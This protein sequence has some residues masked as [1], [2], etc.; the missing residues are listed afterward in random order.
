MFGSSSDVS[1]LVGGT[2]LSARRDR[3]LMEIPELHKV[4]NIKHYALKIEQT[5]IIE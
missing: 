5:Q 1:I 4:G 2:F 3:D